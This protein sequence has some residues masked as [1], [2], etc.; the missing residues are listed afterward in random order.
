MGDTVQPDKAVSRYVIGECFEL[1]ELIWNS[2]EFDP[3]TRRQIA[4]TMCIII[5]G[6]YG[7]LRGE[8]ISKADQGVMAE[9]F[10]QAVSRIEYPFVPLMMLGR[11][12]RQIGEKKFFQPLATK[13]RDGRD[14]F[15]HLVLSTNE[16]SG[17]QRCMQGTSLCQFRREANGNRGNGCS[18][19]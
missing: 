6:Y 12:K 1:G 8:E 19:S 17:G 10:N 13:T 11:F 14:R 7:G 15:M 4:R 18:F 16:P 3:Y 5:T 2:N 9:H